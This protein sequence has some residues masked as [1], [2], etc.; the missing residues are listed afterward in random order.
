MKDLRVL[1]CFLGIQVSMFQL[2]YF[3]NKSSMLSTSWNIMGCMNQNLSRP[4]YVPKPNPNSPLH[5]DPHAYRSHPD[6]SF[7]VNYVFQFM[8]APIESHFSLVR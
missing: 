7:S 5:P 6:L 8:H 4:H 3:Y 1:H 2:G